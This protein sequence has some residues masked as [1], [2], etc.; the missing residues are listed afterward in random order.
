MLLSI[1]GYVAIGFL[2]CLTL[3]ALCACMLSSRISREEEAAQP[4]QTEAAAPQFST[5]SS[6]PCRLSTCLRGEC[7]DYDDCDE[8]DRP[9]KGGRQRG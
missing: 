8:A 1:F 5:S 3:M 6:L 9:Q 4:A 7:P 2:L